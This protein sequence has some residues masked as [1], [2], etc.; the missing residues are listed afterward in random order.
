MYDCEAFKYFKVETRIMQL[1]NY[2]YAI[3]I[4]LFSSVNAESNMLYY[5]D[6]I[7]RSWFFKILKFIYNVN[8]F[9]D[10]RRYY[11]VFVYINMNNVKLGVS[12]QNSK[13]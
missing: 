10:F 2:F 4:K 6:V 7:W 13:E 1:K 5:N 11:T 12:A 3:P 9:Y 8:R